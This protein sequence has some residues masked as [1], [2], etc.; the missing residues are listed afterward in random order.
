MDLILWRHADAEDASPDHSRELTE[1]G[2]S[3]AARVAGWLTSRLPPDI[4]ILVSPAVRAV[5]TAQA[6]GRDYEVLPALAPGASADD[7]LAAA[8]WPGATT[9]VMIVGHQ[10]TLGQVAMRLLTGHSGDLSVKKGGVWW[11]QGGERRGEL[12]GGLRAVAAPD[13]L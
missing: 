3:Q 7:V 12:R 9:P 13:W 8:G 6:L 5:Q 1:K 10:P 11:F 2:R 4:R